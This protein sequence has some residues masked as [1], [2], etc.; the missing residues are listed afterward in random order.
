MQVALRSQQP[1]EGAVLE[2]IAGASDERLLEDEA[3]P[4]LIA[5]ARGRACACYGEDRRGCNSN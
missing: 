3:D 4:N 2:R 5:A 1:A